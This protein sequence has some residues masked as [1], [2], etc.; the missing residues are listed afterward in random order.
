MEDVI[1]KFGYTEEINMHN[2]I[3]WIGVYHKFGYT[4]EINMHNS[5]QWI[6]VYLYPYIKYIYI[7][8]EN[9]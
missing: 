6:G 4:E 9:V 2:S 1:H 7:Y 3:Q 8:I 5:I